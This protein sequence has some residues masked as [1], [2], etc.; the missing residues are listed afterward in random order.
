MCPFC[1]WDPAA[2]LGIIIFRTFSTWYQKDVR[3]VPCMIGPLNGLK[4]EGCLSREYVCQLL[5][6]LLKCL[7]SLG[8]CYVG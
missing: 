5:V 8:T 3:I 7:D 1:Y 6:L 2:N 4:F